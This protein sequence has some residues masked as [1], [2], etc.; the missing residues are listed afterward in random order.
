MDVHVIVVLLV[1]LLAHILIK[2]QDGA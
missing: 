1:V 2:E